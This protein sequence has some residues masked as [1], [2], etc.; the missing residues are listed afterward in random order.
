M[1]YRRVSVVITD[2]DNTLFDWFEVWHSSFSAMLAVIVNK[3]GLSERTLLPE[4]KAIHQQHGTSEYAFLIE[5]IPSLRAKHPNE[6][7]TKVY[8]EAIEAFRGA[9][10]TTL[11]RFAGVKKTLE[12]L[13]GQGVLVVGYT[14]SM[15]FYTGYRIRKL[16]LDGLL[17]YLYSP[18]DH[19]L[20]DGLAADQI[21]KY[22][23]EQYEFKKTVHRLTPPNEFKPNPKLLLDIIEDVG[24][25][26]KEV[27]YVGD[28]LYKDV[29][30]AQE[31][32]VVDV[33][34]NY[35]TAHTR[36]EY[37][38][39]VDVTHWTDK[40]VQFEQDL[41]NHD[42]NATL[43]LNEGFYQI[44]DWFDFVPFRNQAAG[45]VPAV[46]APGGDVKS[47]LDIWKTIVDVQMHFNDLELR[48]RNFAIVALGAVLTGTGFALRSNLTVPIGGIEIQYAAFLLIVGMIVWLAFWF[49][50]RHWYHRLLLGSVRHGIEVEKSLIETLPEA[51]LTESIKRESPTSIFGRAVRSHHRLD[52]FYW[53]VAGIL[54]TAV[55]ALVKASCLF[56]VIGFVVVSL[57]AYLFTSTDAYSTNS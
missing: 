5:N 29:R 15:A 35:G 21:R 7:L 11:R 40:E 18:K 47:R 54:L 36:D 6:D 49:I 2:L 31:A 19:D 27:V 32:G 55:V 8:A 44:L 24:A 14:E 57:V 3:S 53:V 9:R 10:R 4:I 30:M 12:R 13:K 20:P 50:D 28:N 42:V 43:S 33:H 23:T 22:P 51:N 52:L 38:L 48:L 25:D 39:L 16:E 17:D 37:K 45:R 41:K 56:W 26:P 34:A 46:S 1:A